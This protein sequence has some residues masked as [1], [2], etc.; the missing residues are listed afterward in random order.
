V[1][2]KVENVGWPAPTRYSEGMATTRKASVI[3]W[4]ALA[5][6]VASLVFGL[7]PVPSVRDGPPPIFKVAWYWIGFTVLWLT[8]ASFA[9]WR[10]RTAPARWSFWILFLLSA[11]MV[12]GVTL[13][14]AR[15]GDFS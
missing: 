3:S 2:S 10:Y 9:S 4:L 5:G 11:A 12:Y 14:L 7:L 15:L 13:R 6:A 8:L 1:G